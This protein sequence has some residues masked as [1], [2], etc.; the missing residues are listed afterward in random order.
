MNK[1]FPI[2]YTAI[3]VTL[4]SCTGRGNK[5]VDDG[6]TANDAVSGTNVTANA[7]SDKEISDSV[8]DLSAS[9]NFIG[10]YTDPNDGS[11]LQIGNSSNS[12]SSVKINL[13]KLT[14]ID[15]GIG[16][17]TADTLTFI[18]TDAAGNPIKGR[19]TLDGDTATLV[20][21]GSTWEYLPDGSTYH[22]KRDAQAITE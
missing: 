7:L 16:S 21:T 3:A 6:S 18:A 5:P 8:P 13:F 2:F 4:V 14:D 19:I 15:D 22:F 20:F 1:L 9:P 17:V 11:T 10:E 12:G